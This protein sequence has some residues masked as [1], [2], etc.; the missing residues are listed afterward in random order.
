MLTTIGSGTQAASRARAST[1]ARRAGGIDF[2]GGWLLMVLAAL[3]S[4]CSVRR[5]LHVTSDPP[6]AEVRLDDE[7][8][9]RTPLRYPFH[10]YGTR[11]L[12]LYH[13]LCCTYSETIRLDPPWWNRFPLDYVSELLLPFGWRDKRYFEA[14][15]VPGSDV[16]TAPDL[17]SVFERK[18]L[19]AGAGPEGPTD[20]PDPVPRPIPTT[21]EP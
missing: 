15:L 6:G 9:G 8:I 16:L 4:G 1:A 5:T 20:F 10:Y 2:A 17:N 11:K 21:D 18:R 14:E 7:L 3:A 12:T 13:P 19:L